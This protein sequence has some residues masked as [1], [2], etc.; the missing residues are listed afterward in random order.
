MGVLYLPW[1]WV[2]ARMAPLN[3]T[4]WHGY[5]PPSYLLRISLGGLTIMEHLP[6]EAAGRAACLILLA[7]LAALLI[8]RP[9]LLSGLYPLL[10]AAPLFLI[11]YAYREIPKWGTRHATLFAPATFLALGIAWG[12]LEDVRR[13]GWRALVAL[14]L[15]AATLLTGRF[16][17]EADRNLL[18]NPA[19]A[20]E[21]WR[22]AARYIQEHRAPND[23]VIIS[24]GSVFPTWLYYAGGKGMLPMPDD[25]LLDVTHVL[26][27]PEVA[28]QL[29]AALASCASAPCD[30]AT[31]DTQSAPCSVWV[32][33]WLDGITDPT[34]LVET[35]LE[36][37]GREEPA[38]YFRN[39]RV[40]RFLLD[41]P[42]DFPPEPPTTARPDAELLP[43]IR[44]WGYALPA[45][46]H[47]ADRPLELRVWWT[48]ED[49]KPHTGRIYMAS[50]RVQDALGTEWGQD[51]R[52]VTDGDYRPERW[53]P[54]V[55]VFG[56]FFLRLPAGIP[57]GVYTPTLTLFT[58]E[59]K[60]Q[61]ALRPVTVTQPAA[62]P[63][64]PGEFTPVRP[65]G[66]SAPLELLGI[67]L[68]QSEG[69]PC[70][71]ITGELF[72]EVRESLREEYRIAVGV[73]EYRE[74]NPLAPADSQA[75]LRPGD[76][77]RSYFQVAFPCRALDLEANLEVHLLRADGTA[78][79]GAWLGPTVRVRTERVFAEP[80][81][82]YEPV[83][84]DFGPGFATLLGY[85][86]DPPDVRAGQP[87][88]VTLVWR[89]GYT[90]DVPRSV[91][92][93]VTPPDMPLSLVAQHDGWPGLNGRPTHTW[94][95]GEI[96]TDPHPLPGLPAG[97]Y[98][99]RVG[100]YS[101]DGER[102]PVVVGAES[103]PD[104]AVSFPIRVQGP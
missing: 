80:T 35:L 86:I 7:A 45:V 69:A 3:M 31:C 79:G 36:D 60:G 56:R 14:I 100:L 46:P 61:I 5:M 42:P 96:V 22:A 2:A 34:R 76:R 48:T 94:V 10:Y 55:P 65:A 77:I 71:K 52:I 68:F 74:E 58:A 88:T 32:V 82:P 37:V 54:G 101:P 18:T 21:D 19:Y 27:Y 64:M 93:H 29:N 20:K 39:L 70:R 9:R 44:L 72:W 102:L 83:G 1:V 57:P 28:R 84:A 15:T 26:T 63:E 4:Y 16:L 23:V 95:W 89:A 50:F 73:G 17:W 78:T 43:G 75:L 12:S 97:T 38:P 85:R 49:P 81:V 24:T 98:Q 104:R 87:F 59:A 103:P 47:P 30:P 13:R 91:F 41:G 53:A 67:H 8:S 62:P 6:A 66:T 51:D 40:R 99:V 25:P 90:D 92:V 11:A 33:A